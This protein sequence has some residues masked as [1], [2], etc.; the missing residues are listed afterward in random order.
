MSFPKQNYQ[1]ES[2]LKSRTLAFT[3]FEV[4]SS[5]EGAGISEAPTG[6]E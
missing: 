3:E 6:E 2:C 4:F 5:R 1:F